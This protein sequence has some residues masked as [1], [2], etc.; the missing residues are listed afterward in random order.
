MRTTALLLVLVGCTENALV[1]D[2]E[3]ATGT[4]T[5]APP[6]IEV[7]PLAINYGMVDVGMP[8][9]TETVEVTN[10]GVES[11][12]ID[13]VTVEDPTQP[14]TVTAPGSRLLAAGAA[15]TF[16]I[17]YEP[18]SDGETNT[19]VLIA[20]NDPDEAIVPVAVTANGVAPSLQIDPETYDFGGVYVGCV[21][22]QDVT[23]TNV[24][25]ANLEISSIAHVT[26]STTEFFVDTDE[27]VNGPF[28]WTLEPGAAR[29]ISVAYAPLDEYDDTSRVDVASNDP[30]RAVARGEQSG[31]G[32]SY[33]KNLDVFDQPIKGLT[34]ILFTV[35]WSC[36]MADDIARVESNFDVFIA[37]L[38]GM[39]A[40]YQ[41]SAVI[42][43]SGCTLGEDPFIT[44]EMAEADQSSIF[45][46]LLGSPSGSGS[47]GYTEMGF[48][49]I[50]AATTSDNLDN[51]GC[52]EDMIREDGTLSIVG[53]TDEV[54]QSANSYDYYVTLFQTL[55]PDP[56]N[57]V[58]HAI[59]GDY[60]AG[61]GGNEP[62][63][64]W[65]QATVATGGLFL[66]ICASDWASHLE[67]LAEG[68]AANLSSFTLTQAAVPETVEVTLDG[69]ISN[70]GWTFDSVANSVDFDEDHIPPGGTT[71]EVEYAL[72]GDCE[73]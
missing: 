51:G 58:I 11:L 6:D 3:G 10:V 54:E 15:T 37:T 66:S 52:N 12:V 21:S 2:N 49:I 38:A 34:D 53:V 40:D 46:T 70:Q 28:P 4:S 32:Q 29:V 55:K 64:G 33:G 26:A 73:G 20:S 63:Q 42:A 13:E 48:T 17:T 24:G 19:N 27:T 59:A 14:Y 39:D 25:N 68:S 23:L 57:V 1:K 69:V 67:A 41:V 22:E 16:T 18:L 8:A 45:S 43:D 35:D 60:P 62:G 61:C 56:D 31:A 65:Y 30:M 71:I 9:V 72:L 36:S 47:G 5:G 7:T 44:G 50:E